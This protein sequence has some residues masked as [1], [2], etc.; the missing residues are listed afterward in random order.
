MFFSL[1]ELDASK[2]QIAYIPSGLFLLS[3]LAGLNLSYNL[4][5]RL[6]GEGGR[7]RERGFTS[8]IIKVILRM[9]VPMSSGDVISSNVS[10]CL[11]IVSEVYQIVSKTCVD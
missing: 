4:L 10:I 7:E 5:R 8:D 2:N 3:E 6:P 11:T 1:T 9:L